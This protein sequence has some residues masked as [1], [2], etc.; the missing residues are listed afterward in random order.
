MVRR[1]TKLLL[2]HKQ[3][4][5]KAKAKQ[6]KSGEASSQS[7][8]EKDVSKVKCFACHKFKP[9][10]NQLLNK[11]NGKGKTITAAI[12]QMEEMAEK[13]DKN[14]ALVSCLSGTVTRSVW[15]MDSGA[16]RHMTRL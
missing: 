4:K 11:K 3:K 1:R 15:F 5:G 12:A 9:F 8:K 13:F 6:N 7:K 14:S 2:L 16:S 10:S